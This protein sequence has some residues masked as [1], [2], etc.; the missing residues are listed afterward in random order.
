M[1]LFMKTYKVKTKINQLLAR[2][3][4]KEEV[5]ELLGISTRYV[6]YLAMGQKKASSA[7]TYVIEREINKD[8]SQ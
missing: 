3:R 7:L 5:A 2:H 8:L 6:Y 1:L 4:N